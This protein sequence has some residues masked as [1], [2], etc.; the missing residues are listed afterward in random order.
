MDKKS[1]I[2][3]VLMRMQLSSMSPQERMMWTVFLPLMSE[4]K[5]TEL[6]DS[7]EKETEALMDLYL[8]K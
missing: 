3:Q 7:L 5:I 8:D 1:L 2:K 4:K 6:K